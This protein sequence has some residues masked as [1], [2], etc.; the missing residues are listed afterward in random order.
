MIVSSPGGARAR[1]Q[2]V[3][4]QPHALRAAARRAAERSMKRVNTLLNR[5]IDRVETLGNNC[6]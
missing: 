3:W 4:A 2:L 1:R 5:M 6:R